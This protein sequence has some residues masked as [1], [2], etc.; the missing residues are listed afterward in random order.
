MIVST[1]SRS[2]LDQQ[3]NLSRNISLCY[4][5]PQM[6]LPVDAEYIPNTRL[7]AHPYP[8]VHRNLR[9]PRARHKVGQY[10]AKRQKT[11]SGTEKKAIVAELMKLKDDGGLLDGGDHQETYN[12][13]LLQKVTKKEFKKEAAKKQKLITAAKKF[14]GIE[15]MKATKLKKKKE[16]EEAE[17]KAGSAA[18][19]S[20]E[21]AAVE[22]AA[23]M[24][25]FD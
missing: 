1:F 14:L 8:G 25:L 18:S 12:Y 7:N 11:E 4:K 20:A 9:S 6:N 19:S 3:N 22:A 16:K 5:Y 17:A 24:D 10:V 15:K 23:E 13:K 21:G 2:F